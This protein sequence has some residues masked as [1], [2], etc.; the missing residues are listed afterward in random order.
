MLMV[1]GHGDPPLVAT[2]S[3]AESDIQTSY[4]RSLTAS[5]VCI[6]RMSFP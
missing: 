4:I 6:C 1:G 5:L 2:L 3:S